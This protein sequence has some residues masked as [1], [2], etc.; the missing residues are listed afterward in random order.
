[1]FEY[2][3]YKKYAN[4][5]IPEDIQIYDVPI[6]FR[7]NEEYIH[8][9]ESGFQNK[10]ILV[11]IHGYGW[12]GVCFYKMLPQLSKN[13]HIYCIDLLGLGLSSHP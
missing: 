8:T 2:K 4:L 6:T 1:M 10:K 7:D 5:Q 13:F 3:I 11:L 12:N 9:T